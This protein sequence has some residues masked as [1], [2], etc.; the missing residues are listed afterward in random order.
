[1]SHGDKGVIEQSVELNGVTI[2]VYCDNS[3]VELTETFPMNINLL[4]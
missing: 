1:M 2:T 3:C 4:G